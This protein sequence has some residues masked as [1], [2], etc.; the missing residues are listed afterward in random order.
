MHRCVLGVVGRGG[1]GPLEEDYRAS[2]SRRSTSAIK[3]RRYLLR[4]A[5]GFRQRIDGALFIGLVGG[6]TV[7][8]FFFNFPRLR[9][10]VR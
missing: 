8:F 9:W 10:H 6:D 5:I 7:W 4:E 1:S 2:A 3:P